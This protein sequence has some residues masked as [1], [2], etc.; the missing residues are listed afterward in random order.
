VECIT[1]SIR[2]IPFVVG[3]LILLKKHSEGRDTDW[4]A[5]V[6]SDNARG[7]RGIERWVFDLQKS[8]LMECRKIFIIEDDRAIREVFQGFLELEGYGVESFANGK[9]ALARLHRMPE[10]CLIFLDLMMPV[11][12]GVEFMEEFKKFPAT[13]VPIPVYLCTAS[14]SAEDS[15]KLGCHGFVKKPSDLNVLLLIAKGYCQT[16]ETTKY[17]LRRK[18]SAMLFSSRKKVPS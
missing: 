2:A 18:L 17:S 5:S 15:R 8:F 6:L 3:S 13:I 7:D 1:Y 14:G 10:P 11:M 4:A 16:K 12:G 9:D